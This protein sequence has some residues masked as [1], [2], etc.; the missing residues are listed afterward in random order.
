MTTKIMPSALSLK[1]I[2]NQIISKK[3]KRAYTDEFRTV[4]LSESD[5]IGVRATAEQFG[6]SEATLYAWREKREGKVKRGP[7]HNPQ[8]HQVPVAAADI[9]T[10]VDVIREALEMLRGQAEILETQAHEFQ[11]KL[12]D[13]ETQRA[14]ISAIIGTNWSVPGFT[15]SGEAES[16]EQGTRS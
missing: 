7:Q 4:A 9:R 8:H 16:R 13:I 15:K 12:K 11:S 14:Q 6:V 3:D 2:S 5:K 1:N 10:P